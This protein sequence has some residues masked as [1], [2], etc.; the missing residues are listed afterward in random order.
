MVIREWG[1]IDHAGVKFRTNPSLIG[2]VNDLVE[3][4]LLP[5]LPE[6]QPIIEEVSLKPFVMLSIPTTLEDRQV[7][8]N[9]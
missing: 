8:T 9:S 3:Q 7:P 6:R 1:K 5:S 2:P 4:V